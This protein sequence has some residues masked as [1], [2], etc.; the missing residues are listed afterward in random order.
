MAREAKKAGKMEKKLRVLLG[1]YHSRSQALVKQLQDLQDQLEQ[2][3]VEKE[4]FEGLS[5][6]E[7]AAIPRRL[8]HL[9]EDVERQKK[10]ESELQKKYQDLAE[11]RST[12][13]DDL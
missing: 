7:T 13:T 4:T 2:A 9:L 12:A 1:G 6:H 10:R 11:R 8:Q 3:S 5:K